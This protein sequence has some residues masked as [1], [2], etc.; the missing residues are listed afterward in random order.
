MK[1]LAAG[2][3]SRKFK[4]RLVI[5]AACTQPFVMMFHVF[6][7]NLGGATAALLKSCVS[8]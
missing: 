6:V 3:T 4:L 7:R 2:T 8:Y 5:T 1:Y